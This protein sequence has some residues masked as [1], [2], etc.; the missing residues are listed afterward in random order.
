MNLRRKSD[1]SKFTIINRYSLPM[2]K[3]DFTGENPVF[4]LFYR[5]HD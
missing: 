4:T 1:S 2:P 5:K 3:T